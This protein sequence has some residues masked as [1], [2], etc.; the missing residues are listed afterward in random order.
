MRKRFVFSLSALGVVVVTF[1][2]VFV[3]FQLT[4]ESRFANKVVSLYDPQAEYSKLRI[5]YPSDETIF[6]PEIVAPQF[7][8]E[9]SCSK[10]NA[11][12]VH[13]DFKDGRAPLSCL[14][15]KTYWRP[16]KRS[17]EKI[18]VRSRGRKAD[19]TVIGVE[20]S[21][22]EC[23]ES[24]SSIVISTSEDE[25]G[26]PL[27]YREVNL[28]FV[29]A[30]RDP[31][32]IQWRFGTI[33]SEECPPVVLKNLPVCGNCHSFS[34]NGGILGMDVDY[35]NDKG[36]YAVVRVSEDIVLNDEKIIT[37]TAF[38]KE[39][40]KP[41]FGLLSQVSPDGQYVLSTVK[42]RSVFVPKPD[43]AFSQL[44]FPIKGILA[45][46]SLRDKSYKALPGA[47]D[48]AYVQS[49][50]SWS[51]DGK[52]VVFARSEQY[53]LRDIG[54]M[55]TVLLGEDECEEFL[56][57]GKSFKFD[58]YRV[59][60]NDG[61][62]GKAE[63]ISGAS[64][65]GMSNFFAKYS[66]D[67]KWIVFC[68]AED[69]M[70]LQPDSE[71]YIM[72]A[73]GGEPR[74][75]RC[76]TPRMNSW[77]TWS[78][79][80]RWLAFTSKANSD[81]TQLWLT[82]IDEQ[83]RSSPAIVLSHLSAKDRAVNIP[84]F[85]NL[86]PDAIKTIRENFL[87]EFSYL[88]AGSEAAK[89]GDLV[90]AERNYRKCLKLDPENIDGHCNL[91]A[92]LVGKGEVQEAKE[93]LQKVAEWDPENVQ[94]NYNLGFLLLQE[95]HY[96]EA[97]P[98]LEKA[99]ALNKNDFASFYNLALAK[100]SLGKN[101][102]AVENW[103]K[104]VALDAENAAAHYNLA[105]ALLRQ[106]DISEA[107]AHFAESERLDPG[108]IDALLGRSECFQHAGYLSDALSSAEKALR[109]AKRTGRNQLVK[110]IERQISLCRQ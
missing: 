46:Y 59:A 43:L 3:L 62:G 4:S 80:S 10:T 78:P 87:D 106:R 68:K 69:Y 83:G 47:D 26:A 105:L 35:A 44:F 15:D 21:S 6:P 72:P 53:D 18:K 55:T 54:N 98:L 84:E 101:S 14:A 5:V 64:N 2:C 16:D 65:N 60:F 30:V 66:P 8:W 28:P 90:T 81:Y 45:F 24:F 75:M 50:P 103:S 67:G 63:P 22:H 92:L 94:A 96:A 104:A 82:H 33:D 108:N 88:R 29:D 70:L 91:G 25:V 77:H 51:P 73:T 36:S 93:H 41:T 40:Q 48:P 100:D 85:V 110:N 12:V 95:E 27:F 31:S 74:R 17:W 56:K 79:N 39:D 13:F 42:D 38:Q 37:W 76:N 32:R 19:V 57:E 23:I 61:Q 20:D 34:M 99:A 86:P 11:W 107:R 89:A 109:L 97:E 7:R 102:E 71:L 58:L 49:N 1:A 52:Y 9:D